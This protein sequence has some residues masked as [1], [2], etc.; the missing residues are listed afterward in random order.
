[1]C[2]CVSTSG[3][4]LGLRSAAAHAPAAFVASANNTWNLCCQIDSSFTWEGAD[5]M[6]GLSTSAN[7]L[8]NSLPPE[9]HVARNIVPSN[10]DAFLEQ[11]DLSDELEKAQ[12]ES[13]LVRGTTS[14]KARLRAASAPH[15]G[16]WLSAPATRT[17]GLRLT[18]AEFSVAALL[19]IGADLLGSESWCSKCD[20]VLTRRCDHGPRCRGGGNITTRHNSLRDECFFRCLSAGMPAERE[21][22]GLLPSDPRRRPADVFLPNCPG[23]GPVALD[24]AVTCPLQA[25]MVHDAAG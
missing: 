1:M 20:Q 4:G 11:T 17:L 22:S 23:K 24:F 21:L 14:D 18:S 16:A 8:N 5:S 2:V 9:D 12:F 13:L 19:R 10:E 15:A 25:S 6:L 3:G 7:L